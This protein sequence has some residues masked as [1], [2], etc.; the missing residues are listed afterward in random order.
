ML[1]HIG[2]VRTTAN[3]FD[4]LWRREQPLTP[5]HKYF[6]QRSLKISPL[7]AP[8]M[9]QPFLH[10][11]FSCVPICFCRLLL[12]ELLRNSVS[13]SI[14]R[15]EIRPY[16]NLSENPV[17]CHG[18]H[19]CVHGRC[20][21]CNRNIVRGSSSMICPKKFGEWPFPQFSKAGFHHLS[22][23][24]AWFASVRFNPIPSAFSR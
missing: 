8:G 15:P 24:I 16:R 5:G 9:N 14:P 1:A 10:R 7:K 18:E 2:P 3:K 6:A 21:C 19:S 4:L 12:Y 17:Q 11:R 20:N 23:W 22:K 13:I